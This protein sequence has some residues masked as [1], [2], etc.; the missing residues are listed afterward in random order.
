MITPDVVMD[1]AGTAEAFLVTLH[2]PAFDVDAPP[3]LGCGCHAARDRYYL[4]GGIL[5]G[6]VVNWLTEL[7]TGE[8]TVERIQQLM[9]AAAQ[10][11][12]G[13]NGVSFLPYLRG[14]GP[15][16]RDPNAFGAWAGF[17]LKNTR[18][19]LVRA[20]MEGLSFGFRKVV[21][22][23]QSLAGIRAHELRAVGGSTRNAWWQQLK[24]D[25]IGLPVEVPQV[26]EVSAHGAALLAGVGAGV[27]VDEADAARQ[28]YKPAVLYAPDPQRHET[29]D[30]LYA[31]WLTLYPALDAW[32]MAWVEP[33][34]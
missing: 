33:R 10:S 16:L 1:S 21:E 9:H 20:A 15:P 19:D 4:L 23:M 25:V 6:G 11:P 24:A 17:R 34:Q 28:A 7:L 2:A 8:V 29:Y 18:G 31:K 26:T 13:A 30:A 12:V 3:G 14:S 22:G 27:F 5:G 32:D